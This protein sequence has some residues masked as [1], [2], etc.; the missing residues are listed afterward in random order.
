VIDAYLARIGY[1]GPRDPT[2]DV[3]RRIH[4]RHML[5]VPFENLDISRKRPI[6]PNAERSIAKIVDE[7]RGGFCYELNGA[8]CALLRALGFEAD[9][10]N[11]RVARK[12]GTF[13]HD[14]DHMA[15]HVRCSDGSRWLADV[16]F[17][18][19]FVTPL[20]FDGFDED[21]YRVHLMPRDSASSRG[22]T[23]AMQA[24]RDGV[25]ANEYV[26]DLTPHDISDFAEMCD[27][28]QTSPLTSFT[29]GDVCSIATMKGRITVQRDRLIVTENG[30]KTET[31]IADEAEYLAKLREI[32]G[33]MLAS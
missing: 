13:G 28:H 17:G 14:F 10:L 32:F 11:G 4:L 19:S 12:D 6:V 18:E 24:L 26:F 22:I 9:M 33:I 27:Y 8:F 31:P 25:W 5:T 20:S 29:K 15:L 2:P 3:L 7:H 16:G 23:H 1:D 30:T 21:G